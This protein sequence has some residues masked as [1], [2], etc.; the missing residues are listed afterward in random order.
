MLSAGAVGRFE[1]TSDDVLVVIRATSTG[2]IGPC[3]VRL[4]L[5]PIDGTSL[6]AG[7]PEKRRQTGRRPV[8]GTLVGWT[9]ETS[10]VRRPRD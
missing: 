1:M 2:G 5:A 4:E 8:G 6:Q 3:S 9:L 7:R 10:L